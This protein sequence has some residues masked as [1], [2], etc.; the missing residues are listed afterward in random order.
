M[1]L[2]S[3]AI[4]PALYEDGRKVEFGDGCYIRVRAS[5]SDKARKALQRLWKPYATWKELPPEVSARI[6]A[7]WIAQGLLSEMVGFSVGGEPLVLDLTLK[8]DQERLSALIQAPEYKAFRAKVVAL[9]NEDSGFQTGGVEG[10][11]ASTRGGTSSGRSTRK[12]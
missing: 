10:N 7:D 5:A 9:A 6:D 4:D 8:A 3:L 1:E 11:S 12:E 2:T